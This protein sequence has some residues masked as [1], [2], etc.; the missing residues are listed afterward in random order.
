VT[1]T[2]DSLLES[3]INLER[4]AGVA[5]GT[6]ERAQ[7]TTPFG[8]FQ[9]SQKNFTIWLAARL[10][11]QTEYRLGEFAPAE[12]AITLALQAR[13]A[14]ATDSIP[15]RRDLAELSTWIAMS[16]AHQGRAAEAEQTIAPVVAF[17]R[18]LLKRNHG[19]RWVPVE[20]AAALYAQS[21]AD[22][23]HRSA[24]LTEAA[25]Q[26]DQMPAN[27]KG[28]HD[29]R[30]WRERVSEAQRARTAEISGPRSGAGG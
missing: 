7:A 26:L 20:F 5:R 6:L 19:N 15:D 23:A 22:S 17:Y 4:F 9:S 21:L 18:Q 3:A 1:T 13:K 11:G 30:Q 14:V 25:R 2:F 16:Q 24:L 10:L 12:Q 29:V 27:L 28:L 8:E